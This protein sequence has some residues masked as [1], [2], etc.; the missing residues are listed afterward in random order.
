MIGQDDGGVLG[1]TDLF[2]QEELYH[3][4]LG[5]VSDEFEFDFGADFIQLL[6]YEGLLLLPLLQIHKH[7]L[8][9]E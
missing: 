9:L 6:R 3:L 7:L 2:N 4:L 5:R 8:F 1:L